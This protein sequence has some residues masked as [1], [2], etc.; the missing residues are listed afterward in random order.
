[1]VLA[2]SEKEPPGKTLC[3]IQTCFL[4]AWQHAGKALER[5]E[6]SCRLQ[7]RSKIGLVEPPRIVI[8]VMGVHPFSCDGL[9]LA[10]GT[11]GSVSCGRSLCGEWKTNIHFIRCCDSL[12]CSNIKGV[13]FL[14][15]PSSS[16]HNLLRYRASSCWSTLV[17]DKPSHLVK[18]LEKWQKMD[19]YL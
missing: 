16:K 10:D 6:L 12:Y 14:L 1:M 18:L 19:K 11:C 8:T 13:I 3:R 4:S 7:H 2:G 17:W 9:L 15:F 5:E